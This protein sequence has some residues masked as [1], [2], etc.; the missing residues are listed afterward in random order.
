MQVRFLTVA[1][2]VA[3][4]FFLAGC[5][6]SDDLLDAIEAELNVKIQVLHASPD[7]P[8]VDVVVDGDAVLENVD[9]KEG[10]PFLPLADGT[11]DIA[12]NAITPGGDVPVI[13]LA[14]TPLDAD[15][16]YTV[17]ALGLADDLLNAGPE[18]LQDLILANP[19]V[20]VGAGNARVQLVHGSPSAPEVSVFATALDADLKQADAARHLRVW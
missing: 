3:A 1:S 17:I 4:T 10:S 19:D 18:P 7:A 14:G 8:R 11:Y 13:D 5:S 9:F 2:L 15:T 12:V 6:D 16:A 20:A